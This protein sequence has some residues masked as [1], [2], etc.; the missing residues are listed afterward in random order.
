[1]ELLPMKDSPLLFQ[2]A[3]VKAILD[4][5][6]GQ[7]RR[8]PVRLRGHGK[9]SHLELVR[10]AH[11]GE[12]LYRFLDAAERP[13]LID[14]P[15]FIARCPWGQVG[16]RIWVRETCAFSP[17]YNGWSLKDFPEDGEDLRRALATLVFKTEHPK[18]PPWPNTKWRPAIHMQRAASRID[19]SITNVRVEYL[20]HIS[21]RD[22]QLE[23]VKPERPGATH[24]QA[25]EQLWSTINDRE[26]WLSNPLVFVI[27]FRRVR[28]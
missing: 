3:M 27:D 11:D 7:T 10:T 14:E 21:E 15:E 28:P 23:G 18:A 6:K 13:H 17:I 19:L 25:Y 16:D 26:S 9:I 8:L 2:T 24:V 4:G 5:S 20:H 1:M 12:R 22:A